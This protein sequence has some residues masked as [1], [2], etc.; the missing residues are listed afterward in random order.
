MVWLGAI[1]AIGVLIV[2]HEAG[3]FF[4]ARW[5]KMRVDRFSVGFGPALWSKQVGDT[6]FML[7][8]IP[9]G[10]Y[11]QI[12]GMLVADEVDGDDPYA[13]PNRP[14]WQR[15]LTIFAGPATN[16]LFA[17]V[18]ALGLYNC[19]GVPSGT[20]WYQVHDVT[21]GYDAQGKLLPQDR[22][23]AIGGEPIYL[24]YEGKP[25][26]K[27]TD[28]VQ[29]SEGAP[30]AVTVVRGGEQLELM[31]TP[32]KGEVEVT[33]NGQETKQTLWL[34]G[35]RLAS[36][37]ERVDVGILAGT[38][39]AISY[40]VRE[41]AGIVDNLRKI[42][43]GEEKGELTGPVGIA[44][45]IT[46]SIEAGWITMIRFLMMLNVMLGL[47]NLFP[48]PALD[49]GRL[50]FLGYEMATRRR[51]NPKIEAAVH[52]V[53]IMAL[54]LIMVLVTFKDIKNLL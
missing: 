25:H 13:Y 2:V 22:I 23:V 36:E 41:T 20:S 49:G 37:D 28:V 33:D 30:V 51:P 24:T 16:Y 39:H 18:L 26:R 50:V 7:A 12:R 48:L 21:E 1:V 15:F 8:P 9:F 3:H 44:S 5:C 10:G 45:Y 40:P 11:V 34:L 42:F 32:K 17:V 52:M 54:L 53:G 19:A 29:A 47:F 43:S 27:I 6:T 38:W 14:A 46:Q 31:V 4:V 35:V